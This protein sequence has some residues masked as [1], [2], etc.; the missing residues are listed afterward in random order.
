MEEV[1]GAGLT[2]MKHLTD[3]DPEDKKKIEK[4]KQEEARERVDADLKVM[5]EEKREW[6]AKFEEEERQKAYEKELKREAERLREQRELEDEEFA[7][8][9]EVRAHRK[10]HRARPRGSSL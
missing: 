2:V 9:G 1:L 10:A 8:D 3:D 6:E 4:M 7:R 5:K